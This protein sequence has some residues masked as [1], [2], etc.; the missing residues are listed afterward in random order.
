[1]MR[2]Y[3]DRGLGV[4]VMGNVTG[5]DHQQVATAAISSSDGYGRRQ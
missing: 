2:I 3:P 5:Y 1:M 4:T